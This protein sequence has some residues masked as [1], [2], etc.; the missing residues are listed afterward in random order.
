MAE[1]IA[2]GVGA[3]A[4][5]AGAALATMAPVVGPIIALGFAIK[6]CI[7]VFG[8]A[9]SAAQKWVIIDLLHH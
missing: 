5:E 3:I 8:S 2:A 6:I 4:A 9:N 7:D 1:A